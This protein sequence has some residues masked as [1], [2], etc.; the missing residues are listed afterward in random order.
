VVALP[1]VHHQVRIPK[2]KTGGKIEKKC[3]LGILNFLKFDTGPRS[4][5]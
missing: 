2:K 1:Q 5:D 3:V 4:S